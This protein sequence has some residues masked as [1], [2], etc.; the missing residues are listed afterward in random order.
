MPY[1]TCAPAQAE[2]PDRRAGMQADCIP[3]ELV[4]RLVGL[5]HAGEV[6]LQA[7]R[8][9][10]FCALELARRRPERSAALLAPFVATGWWTAARAMAELLEGQGRVAV[11]RDWGRPR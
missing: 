3:A 2:D 5:G 11:L 6:E 10:W 4:A 8:G 1:A 9:E 7:G